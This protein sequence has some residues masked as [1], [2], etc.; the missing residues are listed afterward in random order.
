MNAPDHRAGA[1]GAPSV[2]TL[3]AG[4]GTLLSL[5]NVVARLDRVVNDPLS[6]NRDVARVIGEDPGLTARLLRL[7]NSSL[8]G[9]PGKIDTITRAVAIIGTH[10]LRDLALATGVI[11]MFED[12]GV[13]A[14][15][16]DAFWRHS[17]VCGVAARTL[18]GCRREPNVEHYF[19]AGLLH[20]IGRLALIGEMPGHMR[21]LVAESADS[22]ELLH[23]VERRRLGFDHAEVGA[24]LM[25][26][27]HLP[28]SLALAVALHHRPSPPNGAC[29]T[30]AAIVHVANVIAH[31]IESGAGGAHQVPPLDPRAWDHLR[32]PVPALPWILRQLESQCEDAIGM[33]LG[34]A[35]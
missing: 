30:G 2:D 29:H 22:G 15:Q 4:I 24:A 7:A 32:L 31:V 26:H 6:S 21:A 8:Y 19:I 28:E 34:K 18:A 9:F 20:D 27:W 35:A 10:Q 1:G 16:L 5:P 17:V 25:R 11:G 13:E 3:V 23:E 14:R 33:I 12:S